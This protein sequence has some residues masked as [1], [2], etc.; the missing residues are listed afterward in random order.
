MKASP[1]GAAIS[2][3][4]SDLDDIGKV[5]AI[6]PTVHDIA[7]ACGATVRTEVNQFGREEVVA[8]VPAA[9]AFEAMRPSWRADTHRLGGMEGR[10][11]KTTLRGKNGQEKRVDSFA[12][13]Q[14]AKANGMHEKWRGGGV[15][16]VSGPEEMFWYR[17]CNGWEPTGK[18]QAGFNG[19]PVPLKGVQHDPDGK[20][21]I[22]RVGRWVPATD[23][24]A[25][26]AGPAP[27]RIF[28]AR[29]FGA[30]VVVH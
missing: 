20:P 24:Q 9:V 26:I 18:Y 12:A 11:S 19:Q 8:N 6:T 2:Y 16:L 10:R 3:T 27:K 7:A 5:R 1:A 21:W 25:R 15:S 30:N 14:I 17:G 4:K 29:Y 22:V 23:K 28:D 13:E